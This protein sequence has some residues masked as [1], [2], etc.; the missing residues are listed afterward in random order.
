M[1]PHVPMKTP[2]P[3]TPGYRLRAARKARRWSQM[4]L[5][6]RIGYSRAHIAHMELNTV[7]GGRIA[8]EAAAKALGGSLDH[9]LHGTR[10]PAA[11]EEQE[12]IAGA[13]AKPE[14]PDF[15][16]I[17]QLA[18]RLAQIMREEN[19]PADQRTV[20]RAALAAWR[21]LLVLPTAMALEDRIEL[22]LSERRSGII[23]ARASLFGK[24]R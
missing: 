16:V 12:P 19:M 17:A 2:A 22:V 20:T 24:P 21:D 8:W 6:E 14:P 5:A 9:L 10:R 3:N 18:E 13:P 15:D 11:L 1:T 23:A 4:E 7:G